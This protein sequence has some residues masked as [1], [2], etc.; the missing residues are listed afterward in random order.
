M[1]VRESFVAARDGTRIWWRSAGAGGPPVLFTDGIGCAGF[2]WDRLFPALAASRRV[3]HWNYRGHGKSERPADLGHCTVSD[4]VDDLLAVLD[5]AGE[6]TAV[7]AG[8]SMGVQISLEA[9]RRAPHRVEGLLL[10]LGSPA[11]PLE[12]FHGSRA[13]A[14][15]F[16]VL[17]QAIVAFPAAARIFFQRLFPTELSL[18]LGIWL[19]VNRQ[20]VRREDVRRYLEDLSRVD[21]E[22]W[23]HMLDSAAAHDATDHLPRIAVPALVIGGEKDT[24]TPVEL[25]HRMHRA[26]PGSELLVLAG[27]S[28]MGLL[29]HAEL[30]ELRVQKFLSE[31]LPVRPAAAPPAQGAA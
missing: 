24:F 17:K 10:A 7:L 2:I 8:H 13:L 5:A 26:I 16:P 15:I 1:E 23:V 19:E 4:C 12:T 28:H 31:H 3:L 9:H 27:G 30:V 29:E 25:S 18:Q 6:R 22:V 20:L 14:Q 11:Q 21:P